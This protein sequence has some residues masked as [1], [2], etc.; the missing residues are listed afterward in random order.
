MSSSINDNFTIDLAGSWKLTSP[1]SDHSLS[2]SLPGDVHAALNAEGLIPDPY[3]GRNEEVVQWVA[4]QDW[5]LTR[6]FTLDDAGGDWYLDIDYLDTVASVYVNDALVLE[7]DNCFQRYRPDVS[8]VL[9]AG[10][11]SIR[12]LLRSSIKEGAERQAKQPF[13]IPY[14]TGNSP[15]PNGNMLRK[16]QCHFGWDW[17]IAIAPLGLYGTIAL[18]KLEIARIENVV[19]QQIH[20][21]D[22]SVDLKVIVALF[23]KGTGVAQLY[24]ELDDERVRLDVGVNAGET[25]ITHLFHVDKPTLWWPAG[26]GEQ[27]LYALSVETNFETVTRQIGLR[28][29]ELVTDEDEAGSRFALKVN[30][31]EI[32]ARGANWIPADALFSRSKPELTEDLLQS[33]AD[34]NMNIIRVWGGGFYEHDWF[35]D[36]CDRLGLMVWQDFMFGGAIPPPDDPAFRANTEQEAIEQVD[37]LRD[38]K[39]VV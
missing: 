4:K 9:K 35:Y 2:M 12:I 6:S 38:R 19:T 24:F 27:A 5:E 8:K 20:N 10:E 37:R 11:N 22:G 7:A 29:V 17:N 21:D 3:F 36:T 31:R 18:K 16:P 14:S 34:A 15:I 30:G 28:T 23:A 1:D 32:F 13:Y 39:S 33:A 25:S 26:N